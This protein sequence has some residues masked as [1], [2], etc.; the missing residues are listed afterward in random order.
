MDPSA[1]TDPAARIGTLGAELGRLARRIDDIGAELSALTALTARMAPSWPPRPASSPTPPTPLPPLPMPP[2]PPASPPPAATGRPPLPPGPPPAGM[3][4]H[5]G[6]P[7]AFG[8]PPPLP[9]PTPA[10]QSR[11][12][13]VSTASLLAWT[14][15]AVTLLGVVGLLVLAASR[16]WFGPQARLV[17]GAVLGAVLVGLGMWLHRRE[18]ARTGAVALGAT[19]FATLYLVVAAAPF[20]VNL[21]RAPAV[22]LALVVAGAGLGLADRWRSQLL[23]CGVVVGAA[24]LAPVLLYRDL[25]LLVGIVLVLHVAAAPVALRRG[26]PVLALVAAAG[27]VLYGALAALLATAHRPGATVAAVL[28]VLLA[29]LGTAVPAGRLPAGVVAALVSAAPLPVLVA[30][31]GIAATPGL[32]RWHGVGLAAGA[33]AALVAVA[34]LPATRP[35]VRQVAW[36]AAAVATFQATAVAFDG[37]TRTAV[38]LGQ[39]TVLAVV[40]ALLRARLPLGACAVYGTFG[41]LAAL[42]EDAPLAAL[43]DFPEAPYVVGGVADHQAL[44]TALVIGV[45]VVAAA[46]ASLVAGVRLGLVRPDRSSAPLWAGIGLVALYG[47]AD[48]VITTALLVAPSQTAFVTGH[49]L[50]TVSWTL[51]ALVLLA[52]GISQ[53]ALRVSGLVLVAAAVAKLFLFDSTALDGLA[54]VAAFLGAGLVLLAAG[55]RYARLV[56]EAEGAGRDRAADGPPEAGAAA[57]GARPAGGGGLPPAP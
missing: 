36:S 53:P 3:A 22:V 50:V 24:V 52:R 2:T 4:H 32:T 28:A 20:V 10:R 34:L 30:V 26:W 8:P 39:T 35:V 37:S 13:A 41:V 7:P 55:S 45:L 57:P 43:V 56:A 47:E 16:G 14:G 31:P 15:A 19:G 51:A 25:P 27:P 46:V 29:G 42:I 49:A 48:A 11:R 23:A 44:V 38:L 33:A 12:P 1:P 54:R 40:A 6:P 9:A 18:S 21:G 5:P 17:A